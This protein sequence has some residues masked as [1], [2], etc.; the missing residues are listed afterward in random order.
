MMTYSRLIP[1]ALF[2]LFGTG[3]A[4][5]VDGSKFN[6]PDGGPP[7]SY[8]AAG[9]S[10]P[11]AA[12]QSAAAKARTP[13]PDATYP[14]N[15]DNGAKKVTIHSDW[16]KFDKGAAYV[17]IADMDVDCDGI[18]YKCKG[19]PDGQ[20]QTNFGALAAYEVPF[21]V[22]PDRF[23]TKYAK[24]LPGNNVGAV[25]CNG[26]MFYG[27]YGDSDGDTP[28][29]IGEASW[30]MARTCFPND[31]LNGNSGHG[32]VDVTYILFTGDDSVLPNSALNKNY[33]TN[34]TTLRS[35]G[36]KLMTALAKNLK[37]VVDGGDGGSPTTTAGSNPTSG[38]CEW[39]GHCAGASCKDENDCSDQLVCKSGK[40]ASH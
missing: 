35:M 9:S 5:T 18:D 24:Q 8:F 11:V 38:S 17:W 14:I 19:N 33:V 40:C 31:D 23:G 37:L 25:I 10:I 28:Q 26:K 32:D 16:A 3:L 2:A 6:K 36:D 29:V 20:H 12:L 7:G 30:L 13:V 1:S 15:G 39:E 4:Q 27:I 34:F 22:I 21:F